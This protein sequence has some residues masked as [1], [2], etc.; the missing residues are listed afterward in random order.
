MAKEVVVRF[1]IDIELKEQ[2]EK[3][4]EKYGLTL[5]QGIILYIKETVKQ[6]KIPLKK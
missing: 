6:G 1:E 4:F 3:V 2:A 5:E